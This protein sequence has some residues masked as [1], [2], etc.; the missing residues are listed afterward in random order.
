MLIVCKEKTNEKIVFKRKTR[1][2]ERALLNCV[3][4]TL[5]G[6]YKSVSTSLL[7]LGEYAEEWSSFWS[8]KSIFHI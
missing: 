2:R 4:S 3:L 1:E 7:P 5:V 6:N 8:Q